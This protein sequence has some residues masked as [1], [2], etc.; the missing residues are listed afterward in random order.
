MIN[1]IQVSFQAKD[2]QKLLDVPGSDAIL[3]KLELKPGTK[4]GIAKFSITATAVLKEATDP[5]TNKTKKNLARLKSN[6][7]PV[8]DGCPHP[9][10]CNK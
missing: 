7:L 2:I 10:G 5:K 9:P 1:T 4:K 8:V 3:V 6:V